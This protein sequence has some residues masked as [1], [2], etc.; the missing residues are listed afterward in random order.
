MIASLDDLPWSG[1]LV[2]LKALYFVSAL[3]SGLY[4]IILWQQRIS[5]AKAEDIKKWVDDSPA[6]VKAGLAKVW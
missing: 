5:A 3:L 4:Y 2:S 6:M 1:S